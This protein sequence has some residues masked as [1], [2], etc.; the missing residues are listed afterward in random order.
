MTKD[1]TRIDLAA[2]MA[3]TQELVALLAEAIG[4]ADEACFQYPFAD[5]VEAIET[6]ARDG[7]IPCTS[8]GHHVCLAAALSHHN[9][10]GCAPAAIQPIIDQA[11]GMIVDEWS[12]QYPDRPGLWDCIGAQAGEPGH[13][14]AREAE[15]WESESWAND[16]D[17]YFWKA[18]A[19]I[20][21]PEDH[22]NETGDWEV[23]IDAYLNTDLNYGRDHISWLSCYGSNPNQTVGDFKRTIPIAEFAAMDTAAIEAIVAEAIAAL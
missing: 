15:E 9:S 23:Y 5:Q 6:E 20:Y 22:Q 12:R 21:S 11:N 14:W 1:K 3:R 16:T 4:D 10:T 18:R 8:G 2:A 13:E 19:I 17:C 7:F